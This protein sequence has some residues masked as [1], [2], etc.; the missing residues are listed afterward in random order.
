MKR[1]ENQTVE[2][3][4][5]WQEKYLEWIC[6]Y[7]NAKGG[8]LYV[9]IEDGTKNVLGVRN[10]NKLMEDIPNSIR[11]TMGVV[12][13]VVL[14]RKTGKDVIRIKVKPSAFPVSYRGGY[15]YRTG[16]VKM[17]L[18][19]NALTDFILRK[20]GSSWDVAN[21]GSGK[22]VSSSRFT[23]L[24]S[25]Y[26]KRTGNAL[27]DQDFKSFGLATDD[28]MLTNAGA[29]FVDDS[30]VYQNR[31][32]CTRW[33]GLDRSAGLMDATDSKE[34]SGSVLSFFEYGMNFVKMNSRT[35]WHKL[36]DRRIDFDE[37]PTRAVEE[38]IA[39]ALIHRDYTNYGSEVHIDI[40]D[41]RLEVMSPGGMFDGGVPIQERHDIRTIGSSRRNPVVADVFNRL[42]YAE[43]RGSG[44]KKILDA[45]G[46]A[47]YNVQHRTPLFA[48]DTFFTVMLPSLTYGM[49]KE[50]LIGGV[51]PVMP[52][53]V[54]PVATP[55]MTPVATPVASRVDARL[56]D[57]QLRILVALSRGEKA[58]SEIVDAVDGIATNN[59]RRRYMRYLLD[60]GYV[61]YTIPGKPNSRL[62]KYRLTARGRAILPELAAGGGK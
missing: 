25:Y 40:Y 42:N 26:R 30:P 55:V 22:S 39:N 27:E 7:A 24:G 18:T 51:S 1:D 53:V 2:Y 29:L 37:Y 47:E 36:P 11:N 3:K 9:G 23:V 44:L 10:A 45:Y 54:T 52:S 19:G 59:L 56:S 16:S 57:R 20:T 28:G 58:S 14:Q 61:E 8:V 35:M 6:G 60:I 33:N 17:Q 41:D 13:D 38:A 5:S 21:H 31:L 43:R 50:Q 4:A 15:F 62:Q 46:A 32:F 48:S 49:T 12:A 34:Y